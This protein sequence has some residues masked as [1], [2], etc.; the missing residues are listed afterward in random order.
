M[1]LDGEIDIVT[2]TSSSTVANLISMLGDDWQVIKRT[3]TACI[4]P[5]TAATAREAGLEVDIT[6]QEQTIAGLV[7]AIEEA[8]SQGNSE[9]AAHDVSRRGSGDTGG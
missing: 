1:L 4:G 5:I 8:Y 2:F 3:R 9:K 7:A 6:A